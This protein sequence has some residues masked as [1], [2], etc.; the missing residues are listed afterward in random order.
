MRRRFAVFFLL[1]CALLYPDH[2]GQAA[3]PPPVPVIAVEQAELGPIVHKGHAMAMHGEPKYGPDFKHFDYVNPNAP[4]GGEIKLGAQGT[5]DSF[6]AYIIK[7]IAGQGSAY[8]SLLISS[9][10]EAFTE[11]GL[12]AESME[13]PE[14]RSWIIFHLRAEAR[15]HDGQPITVED[16]IFSLEILKEKGAPFYR[17]YFKDIERAEK[18][19]ERSVKFSFSGGENRELPLITGQMPIFPKHYWKDRKFDETTLEPPLQSGPYRIAEFEAGR[20][21]VVERVKDY[22]GKDLPVNQGINNFDRIRYEYFRDALVIRETLKKG[23]IDFHAENLSKAWAVDYDV[24]AVRNGW[25]KKE[26]IAHQ[27]PTGMQAFIF[28]TRRNIFSAPKVRQALAY[29]FD[30]EWSNEN[31]FYGQYSRTKS[32]FSNSELASVDLPQGEELEILESYR[33]RIPNEV[34]TQAYDVPVTDG[35][36][37]PRGNLIKAFDLLAEAG[38]TVRDLKLVNPKTGEQM[39]FEILLISPAF[40]RIALPFTKNLSRLGI[41]ARVRVVD[42]SQYINRLRAFDFDMITLPIGQSDSPGNEQRDFWGSEAADTPDGRNYGGIRDPVVDELIDL[43]ISAKTRQSLIARTRALDRVLLWGHYVIPQWHLRYQ[44]ILSW[45]KF[46]RPDRVPKNGTA[47][48]YWWFDQ[49][50]A[51]NLERRRS[52]EVASAPSDLEGDSSGRGALTLIVVLTVVAGLFL[53]RRSL[54]RKQA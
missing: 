39:K 5:F 47:F 32:F 28:N 27:R 42:Q 3:T 22:W 26:E 33:G 17:F 46:G 44:R 41:D 45:D 37:W 10:D 9:A 2:K 11:Y 30:F 54:S 20:Y 31:L 40:E 48:N 35:S 43:V 25:L 53:W 16:V 8:E 49:A 12:I 21:I 7:G 51:A 1:F 23:D 6:N 18:V 38:W 50:K 24:P 13:W 4:K 34:F 52:N 29:A 36:G 19:G 14:D 15:W